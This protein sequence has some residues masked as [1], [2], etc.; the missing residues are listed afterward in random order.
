MSKAF[1]TVFFLVGLLQACRTPF[2]PEVASQASDFLVVEGYLDS[3]GK[4]SKLKLSRSAPLDAEGPFVA[5]TGATV[6]LNS[7]S[8][9]SYLLDEVEDGSYLFEANVSEEQSYYLEIVLR[10][11]E[12]YRST[13]MRPIVTPDI[14]D[15]DFL[16]DEEGVEVFITTQ[17]DQFADD[18]LWTYDETWIY[19]PRIR[20]PYIY[21]A[22]IGNV[23]DRR[24]GEHI[25]LCFKNEE[26]PD[27]LLETSSRFEEQVVF[28]QTITEIPRGDE[29][30]MERYSI[31][32]SQKA[33]E[34][35]AVKFWEILK[36]NTEDIGSIFS[37]LPSLIG[38]NIFSVDG[39]DRPVVGQVS[40]GVVR[41]KR[42]Y[43]D[44]VDVSPW[45]YLDPE[46]NDCVVEQ[47][48]VLSRFYDPVFVSGGVL[49]ARA[50]IPEGGTMVIGYFPTS[51]RC[52]DCTLYA[53]PIKPDFWEDE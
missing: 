37:P 19:R 35:D 28:R 9:E 14:I 32:I 18:F 21:D 23:R 7:A 4:A 33:L 30:I 11:G 47:E 8:G 48:P 15:A 26:S 51:R 46:F 3:E 41:Q 45:N 10:N 2:D 49:P 43:I 27:I 52:G 36:K 16:L 31:L 5:E 25:D 24:E 39:L 38:G 42:L 22:A 53:S 13:E 1:W 44:L 50:H 20:V 12:R 34:E 40:L 6:T 29:R 17:G